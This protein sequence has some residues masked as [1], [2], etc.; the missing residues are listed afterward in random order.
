MKKRISLL[1]L[2]G[3]VIFALICLPGCGKRETAS[4]PQ[5][6]PS[7]KAAAKTSFEA[8]TSQLDSGGDLYV[9][10][11]TEQ[12]LQGL[13]IKVAGWRQFL[14][15]I[16]D[17]NAENR[18][19]INKAI[20]VAT[21][22][23]RTSGIEEVKGFGLSSVPR[24]DGLHHSKALLYHAPGSASGF[25]WNMFGREPHAF[26]GLNLLPA[27][28]ALATFSD[29]DVRLVWSL[30]QK[31]VTQSG[32]PRAEELL[33]QLPEG[34]E[35]A[36]GLNWG[37]VL[38]SLGGDFGFV[39]T[40][41]DEKTVSMPLPQNQQLEIPQP[42]LM[43]VAKVK[44]DHIF[45]R[46]DEALKNSGQ[47]S[48]ASSKS[49][50]RMRTLPVPL[51]LPIQIAF[52]VAQNED[53]LFIATSDL[54]VQ[55]ALMVK[56][57]EKAGL[58]STEEFKRLSKDVP[59]QG[60]HFMYVSERFGKTINR[61]QRQALEVVGSTGNRH[62]QWLESLLSGSQPAVSYSVGT[63][64]PQGWLV[65]ANGNQTP[66]RFFLGSAAVP[67]GLI[68]A[69]AIPNFVKAR[70]AAIKNA[71]VS[72]LR[73]IEAAKGQWAMEKQRG[74]DSPKREDVLPFFQNNQFPVCPGGGQYT[75]NEVS[76]PAQCSIPGHTL[77]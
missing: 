9:Y 39:L 62:Q 55:Q 5:K 1:P 41:D 3:L 48:F 13:S 57:G 6:T 4:T 8:V 20:A 58:K 64:T 14:D 23:I 54:I 75:I 15:G 72:N 61:I 31:Q 18:S 28:T 22:L 49:G 19:N 38:D 56:S 27:N 43:F 77:D 42:A 70:Q 60:N 59:Q 33:K 67:A 68:A 35:K 46:I 45:N 71:C 34:F 40:L 16:P 76:R 53:Y 32:L 74:S 10:A 50:L 17:L 63:H 73:L 44:D 25:L 47:Q 65:V 30:V 52:T 12:L 69:V 2:H 26:G 37:K 24:E 51:P 21:N 29:F 11:S 36:T 7:A 66:A